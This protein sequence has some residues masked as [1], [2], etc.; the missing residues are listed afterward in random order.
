MRG[1]HGITRINRD[2]EPL[3]IADGAVQFRDG[4]IE[5]VGNFAELSSRHPDLPVLGDRDAV[6][7]SWLRQRP[8][9]CGIDAVSSLAHVTIH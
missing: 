4:V 7:A 5:S 6:I 3:I 9:P 8:S 2:G 1:R